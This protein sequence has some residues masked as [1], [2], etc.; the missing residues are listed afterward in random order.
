MR[1][2]LLRVGQQQRFEFVKLSDSM[3]EDLSDLYQMPPGMRAS[4][5]FD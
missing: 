3:L 4:G 2:E 1:A 5:G